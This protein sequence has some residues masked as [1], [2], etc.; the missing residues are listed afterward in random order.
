MKNATHL[1]L[2]YCR[3]L[4]I[5]AEL[6]TTGSAGWRGG[7]VKRYGAC[8]FSW[9]LFLFFFLCCCWCCCCRHCVKAGRVSGAGAALPPSLC[10]S[11]GAQMRLIIVNQS[12]CANFV[13][14]ALIASAATISISLF[15]SAAP[16]RALHLV[17]NRNTCVRAHTYI[18]NKRILRF[19][20][21]FVI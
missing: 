10:A 14:A 8:S 13:T 9:F 7:K 6:P 11:F 3:S 1:G 17:C 5:C 19:L 2:A 4:Q 20:F 21:V 18:Y 12:N 16:R 15:I